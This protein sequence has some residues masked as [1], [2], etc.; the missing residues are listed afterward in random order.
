MS[1]EPDFAQSRRQLRRAR[2][3][4]AVQLRDERLP[5]RRHRD[6]LLEIL[7]IASVRTAG[8]FDQ[9]SE[10][11]VDS[12]IALA[13]A[14]VAEP[15]DDSINV[16]LICLKV[17]AEDGHF[18]RLSALAVRLEDLAKMQRHSR[19]YWADTLR[20]LSK[21]IRGRVVDARMVLDDAVR[22]EDRP[23][24]SRT[25][26]NLRDLLGLA[27]LRATL[28][29]NSDT[30]L[31]LRAS[32]IAKRSGDG[33]LLALLDV[34]RAWRYASE[35]A[36]PLE[37]LSS[38]DATF[39]GPALSAY[40]RDRGVAT[41]FPAQMKA[42]AAGATLDSNRLVALPT[43]SGKTLIA[44]MRIAASL[45]RTRGAKAVYVAPYRLLSRQVAG[46]LSNLSKLGF[47]VADLGDGYDPSVSNLDDGA[48][49]LVCTPERLDALVRLSTSNGTGHER[50]RAVLEATTILVF[51]EM[52]L[53]AR[54]GR[55]TRF[56]LLLT[57][58]RASYP[59][60]KILA[61]SAAAQDSGR[62]ADW[63]GDGVR[64]SGARRPTG[65]VE[66]VWESGGDLRQRLP[67][68]A[69]TKVGTLSRP[70]KALEAAAAL[71]AR[72]AEAYAPA[73][74]I[75]VKRQDAESLARQVHALAPLLGES[76]RSELTDGDVS[77][78][79][80]AIEE[81][82]WI[83]GDEH[84]LV[85]LM[86]S[87]IGFHHAGLPSHVLR[88][89]ERLAK[90][91]I[92]RVVCATTTVAEGADLPFLAV[93]IPHLNFPG[94]SRKLDRDLYLNIIGRA[95]RANV[96]V[97]GMVFI[98]DSDAR[99][100]E[101]HVRQELWTDTAGG[102]VEGQLRWVNS[103]RQTSDDLQHF[104]DF[105]SQV[106]GWLGDGGSYLP[107]QAQAFAEKTFSYFSGSPPAQRTIVANVE[108][109]LLGLESAGFIVAGS[110]YRLTQTGVAARLSGLSA[111]SVTRLNAALGESF[112]WMRELPGRADLTAGLC[113]QI[114]RLV[115]EAV[116]VYEHSLTMRAA[117]G[118]SD[119]EARWSHLQ[120]FCGGVNSRRDESGVLSVDI[121]LL[122][123]WM[124][125]AS[126]GDIASIAP[127]PSRANALFGGDDPSK[128][129]SDAAEYIGKMTYPASWTWSA[130]LVLGGLGDSLPRFIRG[131]IELGLPT[132]TAVVACRDGGLTR[133]AALIV[134]ERCG[135]EWSTAE[136]VLSGDSMQNAFLDLP[137]A[138]RA[139]IARLRARSR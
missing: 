76:W 75:C 38:A 24:A 114:V 130:A 131:S 116:E 100:L 115:L 106:L 39:R 37:V 26:Q 86:E 94:H 42:I 136:A 84:P 78:L 93:V 123:S 102:E 67:R 96:S 62:L 89:I 33:E 7:G 57:R 18:A 44:E 82:R 19:P 126:Y 4:A 61:L 49:V 41:L 35:R 135:P 112:E 63:L 92:L 79:S 55:G 137:T 122:S 29:E 45:T 13:L 70:R 81:V 110:P 58:L 31:M 16:L 2:V 27:A 127:R 6:R 73:L 105:Q 88:N 47:A 40:V 72:L 119:A 64:I 101:N 11:Q 34:V 65:T 124:Q 91:R 134:S 111:P 113:E 12:V 56:E 22:G 1:P 139:R 107:E 54:R 95:G 17:L 52:H 98:L 46:E 99:T 3:Q 138:D 15:V 71:L 9:L 69:P 77:A 74:A 23:A 51:D 85:T 10:E 80:E 30:S 129:A 128:R 68:R 36:N 120:E 21:L 121:E 48:D 83:L 109:A 117:A 5:V 118:S 132:E 66:I 32:D 53:I 133:N 43:S 104:L 28:R 108:E 90:R 125:G 103:A 60:M 97:E 8:E 20:S 14:I 87:G 25:P 50:A 59:G